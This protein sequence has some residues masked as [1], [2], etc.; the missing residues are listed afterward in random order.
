MGYY[1]TVREGNDPVIIRLPEVVESAEDREFREEAER[2]GYSVPVKADRT[3]E[4]QELL[5]THALG[6][7]LF[8]VGRGDGY[9]VESSGESGKAYDFDKDI[10]AFTEKIS[11]LCGSIT[12]EFFLEG[13]NVG[14][15]KR[16]RF[17]GTQVIIDKAQLSFPDGSVYSG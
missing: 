5:S 4:L 11:V 17:E 15:L 2:R 12:G 9:E 6:Y 7:F 13:E 3:E 10:K 1:S 16:Y 8:I 14:D